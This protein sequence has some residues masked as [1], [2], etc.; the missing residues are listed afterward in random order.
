MNMRV[1][2]STDRGVEDHENVTVA[3]FKVLIMDKDNVAGEITLNIKKTD[4][5]LLISQ[6]VTHNKD[7]ISEGT[8]A[9]RLI[10]F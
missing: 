5:F 3:A 1:L 4:P 2:M 6:K 10:P 9:V 8:V 7:M